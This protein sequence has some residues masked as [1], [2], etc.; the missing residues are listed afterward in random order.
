[1]LNVARKNE[2]VVGFVEASKRWAG[3]LGVFVLSILL[4]GC[5]IDVQKEGTQDVAIEARGLGSVSANFLQAQPY[6]ELLI[7]IS[8]VSGRAPSQVA[9]SHL[10][11]FLES[12]LNKPRGVHIVVNEPIPATGRERHSIEQIRELERQHRKYYSNDS[13]LT[14]FYLFPD[15]FSVDDE[16][17][18]ESRLTLA[19][20]HQATS[21]VVFADALRLRAVTAE[22]DSPDTLLTYQLLEKFALTHEFG[23]LLGLVNLGLPMVDGHLHSGEIYSGG[24]AVPH[25]HCHNPRCLMYYR[26]DEDT[27]VERLGNV[28]VPDLD[29]FC[30][31]DL[32]A[33]GGR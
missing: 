33:A 6:Q 5:G 2:V 15:G 19:V 22:Q 23:H 21:V 7:E 20:A 13:L 3:C 18:L 14:V 11:T 31:N 26:I 24:P 25:H 1:M 12:K 10:E 29:D 30:M 16:I 28:E 9:L 17:G 27:L 4:T 32:R 8:A